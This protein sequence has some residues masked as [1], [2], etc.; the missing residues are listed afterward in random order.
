M[1]MLASPEDPGDERGL[2]RFANDEFDIQM[3]GAGDSFKVIAAGLA[4]ALGH[5]DAL[6]LVRNIPD[7]EK[8][9]GAV[10]THGGEQQVW[11]LT[12]PGF[13]RAIG[14]RQ[15]ARVRDPAMRDRVERFQTWVYSE[16]LPS[17]RKHGG[18]DLAR[19]TPPD[20]PQ[21]YEEAL[22]HLLDKVRE[23]KQLTSRVAELEPA[24]ESWTVLAAADGDFSVGDA[25][26]I[27]ARDP[28]IQT[29]PRRLF[30]LLITMK[31]TYR[32]LADGRPRAMQHAVERQWLSELP[33]SHIHPET[34]DL[35]LDPPQVRV[36]A[37]GLLELHKRLGGEAP[38]SI[39]S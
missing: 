17:I 16:V 21:D 39:A 38:L 4:K 19:S 5:R 8:G 13:Y 10:R 36:T 6:D 34:G 32:Q 12:E 3:I 30:G 15:A 26:K 18:Y 9:Y 2:Q 31:W 14:Q 11:T 25:A 28:R 27:L 37:K 22:V 20:L 24:A 33:Q 29:G 23:N 35:V 1:P 7:A